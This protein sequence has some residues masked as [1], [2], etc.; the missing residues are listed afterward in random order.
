[1]RFSIIIAPLLL[2]AVVGCH[3]GEFRLPGKADR[4]PY[5]Y[6][7]GVDGPGP[8]VVNPHAMAGMPMGPEMMG[9]G[10]QLPQMMGSTQVNFLGQNGMAI[11]WPVSMP[12]E[13]DSNPLITPGFHEFQYANVYRLKL[14][15]IPNRPGEELYPTLEIAPPC[16][17]TQ[18][19][20]QHSMVPIEFNDNDIDQALSGNYITKVIYLPTPEFQSLATT[21]VGT[22]VSTQL[23]PGADPIREAMRRGSILAIIRMGN[24]ILTPEMQMQNGGEFGH[25]MYYGSSFPQ[26]YISGVNAPEYGRPLI[27]TTAGVP[28]PPSL[29]IGGPAPRGD[30]GIA[31]PYPYGNNGQTVICP[32][33]Q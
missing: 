7:F 31:Y 23:E 20:L 21:G 4:D 3:V 1:M 11:T 28:G 5:R 6:G 24:K 15:N 14:S 33:G 27:P 10:P 17:A 18:A 22:L 30:Y 32:P 13:F 16:A 26:N 2:V 9:G 19:F 25:G 12:G 8:G 29:P